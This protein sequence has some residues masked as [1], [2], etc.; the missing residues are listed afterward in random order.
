M[1][2]ADAYVNTD[3]IT[4][5]SSILAEL[6]KL[7]SRLSSSKLN[8]FLVF[9]KAYLLITKSL[10]QASEKN[11]FDN[12]KFVEDFTVC[13]A[14]YYFQAIN[15]TVIDSK[16]LPVAW[17]ILNKTA[18]YKST[19]NF[20]YLLMGANAHINNDLPVTMLKMIDKKKADELLKD[21]LRVDRIL[22]KSGRE[23]IYSF[24][25]NRRL[26][27]FLKRNFVF[28]YYRP[29]M[30][31]ILYWRIKAWSSYMSIKKQTLIGNN[32]E[33]KSIHIANRFSKLAKYMN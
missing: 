20:I 5:F 6:S 14:L 23:I 4:S 3:N 24:K 15:D 25:E 33:K 11:Y 2:S 22:M 32:Y 1:S 8:Q 17:A 7:E 26:L 9:N 19:P 29:V 31:M 13:F 28:I 16:K 21:V 27:D 30:Y 10:K 12:P 18:K